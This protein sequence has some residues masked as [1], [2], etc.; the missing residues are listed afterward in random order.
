[1]P[2]PASATV[3][4]MR[5]T[6][7]RVIRFTGIGALIAV[8]V[9]VIRSVKSK[10]KPEASGTANWP[11]L[12]EE[13]EPARRS[14]PVKFTETPAEEPTEAPAAESDVAASEAQAWVDPTDGSCPVDHPIKAN[15]QSKIFHVPGG[16]SYERTDADRCYADAADAEADGFRQAKR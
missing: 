13:P 2:D 8:V 5:S 1:M 16:S 7:S 9:G 14:G 11:P 4:G 3:P 6:V 12:V 15:A 10:P